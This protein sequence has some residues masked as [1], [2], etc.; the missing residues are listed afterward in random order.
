MTPTPSPAIASEWTEYHRDSG[1]SGLGPSTPSLTNPQAVWTAAVDGDV[2]A[3]PLV[4]QGHVIVAT[5]NN[6]VYSLDLFTGTP[7]WKVHLGEPVAASSL[8]CGD[9]S[10]VTGITGT[11]AI[12]PGAQRVYAVAFLQ[13]RHH[14]LFGLNL[15]NGSVVMQQDVDPP[16]SDPAVQQER[17]ALAIGSGFVYV[18][19][20]GLY[21]DCGPYRGYVIGVPVGGGG[22]PVYRVRSPRGAGIWNAQ[23]VAVDRAGHVYVTTGN[24]TVASSSFDFSNSVV[25]LSPDLQTVLSYFAP[26][27]WAAL[28]AGDVDLGSLGPALLPSG[29][30]VAAGKEGVAYLLRGGNLGGVGGQAASRKVCGGAFGGAAVSGTTVYLPCNDGLVAVT[31]SA[32]GLGVAWKAPHPALGSPILAAGAVW[33]IEPAS[34]TLYALDPSDG[35]VLFTH[36]LGAAHHFTTPAATDGFVIAPAGRSVVAVLTAG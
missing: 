23:G 26:A 21:G 24:A 25:E 9:I 22:M 31:T 33:A 17:G 19:L 4:F 20:G 14:M 36:H 6:T 13:G 8:P 10:P 15:V 35:N 16:G 18:P 7:I 12:D 2:Y 5:E 34:A 3:S 32:G 28:D 27:N 30:V 29:D 11:P 1:R